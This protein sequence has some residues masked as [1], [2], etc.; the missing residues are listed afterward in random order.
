MALKVGFT[1]AILRDLRGDTSTVPG[2]KNA[3]FL[4]TAELGV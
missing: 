4:A 1:A 2:D 3:T